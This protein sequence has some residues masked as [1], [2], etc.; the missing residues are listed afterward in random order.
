MIAPL[1]SVES[2]E[3]PYTF[4]ALTIAKMLEPYTMLNGEVIKVAMGIEQV[5]VSIIA[6]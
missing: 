3:V 1:P 2:I 4:V 6:V 5:L